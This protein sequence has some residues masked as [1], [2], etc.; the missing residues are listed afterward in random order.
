MAVVVLASMVA[1][2]T[3]PTTRAMSMSRVVPRS[4][5][6]SMKDPTMEVVEEVCGLLP[7]I[8][9]A[10]TI[11]IMVADGGGVSDGRWDGSAVRI[12]QPKPREFFFGATAKD[13]DTWLSANPGGGKT[14]FTYTGYSKKLLEAP[15]LPDLSSETLLAPVPI[16]FAL[17]VLT[18]LTLAQAAGVTSITGFLGF[19]AG[20]FMKASFDAWNAVAPGMG[21][22]GAIL[23]Y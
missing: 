15:T 5:I 12:D 8:L 23:K 13:L 21:L 18:E 16:I 22:G 10:A 1:G 19:G 20:Q 4:V 9:P 17:L 3:V 2:L 6:P 7:I 14:D 11:A